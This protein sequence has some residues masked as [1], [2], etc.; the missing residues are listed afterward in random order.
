MI[1][2]LDCGLQNLE[3]NRRTKVCSPPQRVEGTL[4]FINT[5][6]SAHKQTTRASPSFDSWQ[7]IIIATAQL[8]GFLQRGQL[9]YLQANL[10]WRQEFVT[11]SMSYV[12]LETKVRDIVNSCRSVNTLH[13][14]VSELCQLPEFKQIFWNSLNQDF[15]VICQRSQVLAHGEITVIQKAFTILME[16]KEDIIAAIELYVD[17]ILGL[18]FTS[19]TE[20]ATTLNTMIQTRHS[21]L[22]RTSTSHALSPGRF[23][24]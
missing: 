19:E 5:K 12:H 23:C 18:K 24:R 11:M 9:H 16:K 10:S 14:V 2:S 17:E 13:P 21:I 22:S 3:I 1:K 6:A 15:Y 20:R 7:I 8:T 4:Y